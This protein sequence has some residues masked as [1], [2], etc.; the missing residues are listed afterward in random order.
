MKKN[1]VIKKIKWIAFSLTLL[2]LLNFRSGLSQLE[3][4]NKIEIPYPE[5]PRI[6]ALDA[7]K[8]YEKGE[9]IIVDVHG[10]E[11]HEGKRIFGSIN[12]PAEGNE[13]IIDRVKINVPEGKKL[14]LY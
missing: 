14:L 9:A 5:V 11:R 7:L 13:R 6:G 1:L 3:T 12:I 10:K 8:L 2:V 4:E